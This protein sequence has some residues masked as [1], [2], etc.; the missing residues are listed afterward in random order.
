MTI[1]RNA[2][3]ITISMP[4]YIERMQEE[5]ALQRQSTLVRAPIK[6]VPPNYTAEPQTEIVDDSPSVSASQQKLLQRIIGKLLFY[7]RMVDPT[8]AV[9]VNRLASQQAKPTINTMID[10]NQ[11]IQYVLWHPSPQITFTPSNMQLVIHSDA[12]HHSEPKARS[13]AGGI[14]LL[15]SL[16][17]DPTRPNNLP[18]N[19]P[20]AVIS[21]II[22][23]VC[24]SASESEYA[25]LFINAQQGETIRQILSDLGHPQISPTVIIYDNLISGKIANRTCK[26]RRSKAIATRYHWIQDRI[27]MRHFTLEWRP[28]VQNLADFV[29]KAH[30]YHHFEQM[31]QYFLSY[32]PSDNHSAYHK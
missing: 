15:G 2:N 13:R 21:T 12:S 20:I 7:S 10:M 32:Q 24:A 28:G 16:Q 1:Q 11:L 25:A 31:S 5:L 19:G 8:I 30:P 26:L 18:L 3:N 29:T 23:T 27:Q 14:F 9:A 22:P 17:F 4:G 6:Y